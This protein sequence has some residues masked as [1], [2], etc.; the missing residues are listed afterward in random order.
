MPAGTDLITW[1]PRVGAT[2]DDRYKWPE[3]I[4]F[5]IGTPK[6]SFA[7]PDKPTITEVNVAEGWNQVIAETVRRMPTVEEQTG[8]GGW[9][10]IFPMPLAEEQIIS[11]PVGGR[12][13]WWTGNTVMDPHVIARDISSNWQ[14]SEFTSLARPNTPGNSAA[15]VSTATTL[16]I[17]HEGRTEPTPAPSFP[18]EVKLTRDLIMT[19]RKRLSIDHLAIR[20][21]LYYRSRTRLSGVANTI[22]RPYLPTIARQGVTYPPSGTPFISTT[23]SV[24][25]VVSTVGQDLSSPGSGSIYRTRRWWFPVMIPGGS[26]SFS[27]G[28]MDFVAFT[29]SISNPARAY[30]ELYDSGTYE[31]YSE[32]GSPT[33]PPPWLL[34]SLIGRIDTSTYPV[35]LHA[36]TIPFSSV[37]GFSPASSTR[38]T[39]V[40]ATSQDT[41]GIPP[42]YSVGETI[43]MQIPVTV[44]FTSQYMTIRLYT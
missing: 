2:G 4:P 20:N 24:Y 15:A 21:I 3:S 42:I 13:P 23:G 7:N 31:D 5:Y 34:G 40:F 11:I 1:N 16:I 22:N 39:L 27:S 26:P 28:Q 17:S 29:A 32:T 9:G 33:V 19:L 25:T 6:A 38:R 44:G 41:T 12:T 30:I 35:G 37:S 36:V 10:P 14:F 43:P 18:A 8:P